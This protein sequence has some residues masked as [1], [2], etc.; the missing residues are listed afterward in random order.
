[1]M[2]CFRGFGIGVGKKVV[3]LLA[4]KN[5]LAHWLLDRDTASSSQW[6]ISDVLCLCSPA[7]PQRLNKPVAAKLRL[8]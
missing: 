5:I 3:R 2:L 7:Q 6:L 8:R 1:M 4:V